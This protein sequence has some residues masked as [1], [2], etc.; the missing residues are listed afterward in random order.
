[1]WWQW[2]FGGYF[3][4]AAGWLAVM[5][6]RRRRMIRDRLRAGRWRFAPLMGALVFLAVM[7]PVDA[8]GTLADVVRRERKVRAFCRAQ[9]I[10][11]SMVSWRDVPGGG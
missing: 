5:Y 6:V 2:I 3:V 4:G 8:V 9:G 7:W 10:R 11:R 1:M